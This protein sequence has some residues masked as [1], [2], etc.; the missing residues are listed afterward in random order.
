MNKNIIL[1]VLDTDYPAWF[2]FFR[3][4]YIR[5]QLP[6]DASFVTFRH[7][8][9]E[10]TSKDSTVHSEILK[11][12]IQC[13][14]D[15]CYI[16]LLDVDAY[17]VSS[18]AIQT[19]FGHAREY[20]LVGNMQR[21]NCIENNGHVF[22]APSFMC[23]QV[24]T[25]RAA[26][27]TMDIF[28]PSYRGDVLEELTYHLEENGSRI[29]GYEPMHCNRPIWRLH[30]GHNVYGIATTF[31][32]DGQYLSYHHF[33]SRFLVSQLQFVLRTFFLYLGISPKRLNIISKKL[34][35]ASR[36]EWKQML[37]ALYV[38]TMLEIR[39]ALGRHM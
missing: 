10:F 4:L 18:E 38:R 6:S 9:A 31:G 19:V 37:I 36:Q 15:D 34:F 7:V 22:I 3:N 30:F 14:S 35:A 24:A 12:A 25:I 23:F 17:P 32:T 27:R 8:P 5:S 11:R 20:K 16:L 29:L 2:S 21:T 39:Y 13:F 1:T 33:C 28:S 26:S